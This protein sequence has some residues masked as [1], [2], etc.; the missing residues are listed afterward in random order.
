M[1]TS[2]T[3]ELLKKIQSEGS[4]EELRKSISTSTGLVAYDLQAPAK[5]LYPVY[6]PLRNVIPRVGGGTGLATN[7]RVVNAIVGSGYDAMGW[8][9]EGQRSARM[10]YN[11][12][13]KSAS[14]VTLGEEDQIS[15]E[16]IH[17]GMGFEDLLATMQ[18]RLLQKTMLKEE[19]AILFGNANLSLGTPTAPTLS[20]TTSAGAT[21]NATF[22]VYV[23][24]LTGEGY[25]NSSISGGV[26]TSKTITG[27]DGNT[28]T[29]N[30]GS[31]LPSSVSSQAVTTG[32]ALLASTPAIVGAI[33]YAWF[34]GTS[35]NEKL[36]QITTIN[37]ASFTSLTGQGTQNISVIQA[38]GSD[39]SKNANYAFDGLF[40]TCAQAANVSNS[41][42][43]QLATGTAGTGT[44]M[45]SSGRGSVVEIDTMLKSMYD[46]FQVSPTVLYVNSQELKNI[47]NKVLAN[48][49]APLLRYEAPTN[50]SD[51]M[52]IIAGNT[53]SAYFNPF[54]ND[55]GIKIPVK[56]HPMCPPG[57]I[58]G[59]A[60]T[61]PPA[62]LSNNVPNVAEMKTRKDYYSIAWPITTRQQAAGVYMEEVLAVYAPFAMGVLSNIANG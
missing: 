18:L 53:V 37:S 35:G 6:T 59:W 12:S 62:Y 47:T 54:S 50:G 17:A 56:I 14:Y 41:Y 42:Y 34:V 33:A 16:A 24:A 31:S 5:N 58:I 9:A 38:V 43:N 26:A 27:A 55:G 61:L 28:F 44:T 32:N 19:S 22:N 36:L 23:V 40:S 49:S 8:V 10:S 7:W 4:N 20:V 3:L 25:K 52:A 39:C 21:L 46:Q 13:N 48:G 30:G 45:T 29:L 57:T 1:S 2:E 60:D 11:T 51:P 15:Y